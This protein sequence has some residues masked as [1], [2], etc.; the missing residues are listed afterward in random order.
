MP[1]LPPPRNFQIF[2]FQA[3]SSGNTILAPRMSMGKLQLKQ[4]AYKYE[5]ISKLF[6]SLA[7]RVPYKIYN[8]LFT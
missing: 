6:S 1:I 3:E 2:A 8:I 7:D 5:L 4:Y